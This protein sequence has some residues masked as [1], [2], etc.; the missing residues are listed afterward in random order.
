MNAPE[1]PSSEKITALDRQ[2]HARFCMEIK[3]RYPHYVGS[4]LDM[5]ARKGDM[6]VVNCPDWMWDAWEIEPTCRV[7]LESLG[8][9]KVVIGDT[10]DIVQ[11]WPFKYD[12]IW[13]DGPQGIFPDSKGGRHSEHLDLIPQALSMLRH[14]WGLLVL[15]VNKEP[16]N[17]VQEGDFGLD[18]YSEYD[19][20]E[21]MKNRVDFYGKCVIT[22]SEALLSYETLIRRCGYGVKSMM[23]WPSIMDM[24]GMPPSFRLVLEITPG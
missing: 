14:G 10:Y 6:S 24:P 18:T 21:W 23:M 20:D 3:N 22:E 7:A 19:F 15:Y 1:R 5:F 4:A 8:C 9:R 11:N 16:Y 12:M 2:F 17:K 13:V